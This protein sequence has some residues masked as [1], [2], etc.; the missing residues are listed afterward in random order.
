MT[1]DQFDAVADA[2]DWLSKL[3]KALYEPI[4][5]MDDLNASTLEVTVGVSRNT[6]EP[7][8]VEEAQYLVAWVDS[9]EMQRDLRAE[10][11]RL[12]TVM[13]NTDG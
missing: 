7:M 4:A 6:G 13:E 5:V 10:A 1:P 3:T 9:D 11:A 2:L 12:R 8:T